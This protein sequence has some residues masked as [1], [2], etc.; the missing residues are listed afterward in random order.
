MTTLEAPRVTGDSGARSRIQSISRPLNGRL[1][2][3][4]VAGSCLCYLTLV[5]LTQAPSLRLTPAPTLYRLEF[6]HAIADRLTPDAFLYT[7]WTSPRAAVHQYALGVVFAGLVVAWLCSLWLVRPGA[8]HALRLRWI[9]LAVVLFSLPLVLLPGMF[10]GDMYLYSFYG[11]MISV[12]EANPILLA[13][14]EFSGDPLYSQLF[15]TWIPAAYG[16][17]WLMLSG[18][19]SAV[20]GDSILMSIVVYKLALLALHVATTVVVWSILRQLRPALATWGA[21]F[22]GW[23]PLVLVET[24]GSGHNDVMIG[25]FVALSLLS[26]LNKRWLFATVFLIAAAMVKL[27]MLLLLPALLIA[28]VL[29]LASVLARAWAV[30]KGLVVAVAS[31]VLMYAPLWAGGALLDNIRDN[32][33]ATQYQNSLWQFVLLKLVEVEDESS[34]V[35]ARNISSIRNVTFVAVSL[36]VIYHGL[37]RRRD[38]SGTWV[39]LWFAY[40]LSLAWVWPWYFLV[41]IPLAAVR[42]PGRSTALAAALTLGGLLFWMGWPEPALPAAPWLFDYRSLLLFAPA[43][44]VMAWP[45]LGRAVVRVIGGRFDSGEEATSAAT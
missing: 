27:V 36:V 16:P 26:V 17:V 29:S 31:V 41:V 28:W 44:S 42:G 24:A 45:A 10:S 13:P 14:S 4:S 20:A 19:L 15:W 34:T 18:L 39:A 21:V 5:I 32:P 43:I 40:C 37:W 11:R 23:N 3:L 22:Y 6:I 2:L 1:L 35:L 12:Y 25:L 8:G 7:P 30:V 9:L 38:L 33:A